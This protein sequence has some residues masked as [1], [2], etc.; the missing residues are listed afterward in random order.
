MKVWLCRV[1][2][3]ET[4]PNQGKR[5]VWPT[6]HSFSR[7]PARLAALVR[8]AGRRWRIEESFQQPKQLAGLDQHQ[9]RRGDSYQRWVTLV[10]WAYALLVTVTLAARSRERPPPGIAR[11][12]VNEVR[13]LL[14][15]N[16]P[17]R[18]ATFALAW[19]HWRRKHQHRAQQ[20]HYRRRSG[21]EL[22][23]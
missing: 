16:P 7:V 21:G 6:L 12:S 3:A 18:P 20:A 22:W 13:R 4:Y 2:H 5:A 17:P 23:L 10:M 11:L 15:P 9:V 19:S 1:G 8:V 14:A